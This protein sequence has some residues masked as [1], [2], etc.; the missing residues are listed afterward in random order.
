MRRAGV[1]SELQR[2]TKQSIKGKAWN[3]WKHPEVSR[4]R[5]HHNCRKKTQA[6]DFLAEASGVCCIGQG[7]RRIGRCTR[8]GVAKGADRSDLL[9]GPTRVEHAGRPRETPPQ[10]KGHDG[11][12]ARSRPGTWGQE[13]RQQPTRTLESQDSSHFQKPSEGGR[14]RGLRAAL[15]LFSPAVP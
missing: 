4:H 14:G 8:G 9:Q 1:D 6:V 7:P 10:W 11:S 15:R 3:R 2:Q 5:R 13:S 12:R